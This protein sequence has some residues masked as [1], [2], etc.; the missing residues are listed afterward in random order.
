M[1]CRLKVGAVIQA[2]LGSSRLPKKVL[3]PLNDGV[4]ILD[5]LIERISSCHFI[6]RIIIA[7]STNENDNE[8]EEYA[9]AKDVS[10]FRG[11]EENVLSRF[12]ECAK[13]FN[14]ET[15]IRITADDPFKDP[16]VIKNAYD[17]YTNGN[18][19]YVSNTIKPTYPEGIDIEIFKF[20]VLEKAF[21]NAH[22]ASETEHVTP[23][24]WKNPDI[25]KIKN[26]E[27]EKDYSNIRITVDYEDDY[28]LAKKV[29]K[30]FY[31]DILF[32]Y[33]S[34]VSFIEGLNL[35]NNIERNEGYKKSLKEDLNG[36]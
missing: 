35:Q 15:I 26:I 4:T 24:I 25:F 10:F 33:K 16:D 3:M 23:Y 18:Y 34:I 36:S 17:V 14:L 21:E 11:C 29:L 12:Y 9:L 13:K 32:G 7:T 30:N 8:L 6:D 31:P 19:D 2:R 22:L 1:G 20:S 27:A 28:N 5:L